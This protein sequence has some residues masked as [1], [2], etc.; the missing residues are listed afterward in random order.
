MIR[1]HCRTLLKVYSRRQRSAFAAKVLLL[2]G[3]VVLFILLAG[4]LDQTVRQYCERVRRRH[5]PGNMRLSGAVSAVRFGH[6]I[7]AY[8]YRFL[9]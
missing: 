7:P 3:T 9:S 8:C 6:G 4:R 5:G 2:L 1:R